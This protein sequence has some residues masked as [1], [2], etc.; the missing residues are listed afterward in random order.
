MLWML[1]VGVTVI[2]ANRLSGWQRVVPILCPLW[3]PVAIVGSIAFGEAAGYFA[4]G[5][6][7]VLWVLLGYAV[8]DG[9]GKARLAAPEPAVR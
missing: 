8:R 2:A 3:L 5:M 1:A 9:S 7:A 4:L 6:T